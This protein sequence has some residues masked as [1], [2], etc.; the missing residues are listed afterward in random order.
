MNKTK[1]LNNYNGFRDNT[2][3]LTFK[4][5]HET[6]RV[7]KDSFNKRTYHKGDKIVL[8]SNPCSMHCGCVYNN[9]KNN[10]I[11]LLPDVKYTIKKVN[12]FGGGCPSVILELE[13]FES[14][15]SYNTSL[16]ANWFEVIT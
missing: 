10:N 3:E 1:A 11:K 14:T 2:V 8:S 12:I 6:S 9:V 4:E 15:H 5:Y 7:L 13:E 16:P